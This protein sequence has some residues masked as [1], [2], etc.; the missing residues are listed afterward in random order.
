LCPGRISKCQ[1]CK[2]VEDCHL[3]GETT[4]TAVFESP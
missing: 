3:S 2:T 1:F 4:C